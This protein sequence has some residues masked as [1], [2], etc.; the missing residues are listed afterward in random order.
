[1]KYFGFIDVFSTVCAPDI[2]LTASNMNQ[3]V[4][5]QKSEKIRFQIMTSSYQEM[6]LQLHLAVGVAKNY[7]IFAYMVV[8]S[9]LPDVVQKT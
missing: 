7:S 9:K 8:L 1:M 4:L 2:F 5:W 6:Q 3:V